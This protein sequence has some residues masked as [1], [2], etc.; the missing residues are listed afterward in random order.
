M[1]VAHVRKTRSPRARYLF[2]RKIPVSILIDTPERSADEIICACLGNEKKKKQKREKRTRDELS[3]RIGADISRNDEGPG[4]NV[5]CA[6]R[7][8]RGVTSRARSSVTRACPMTQREN[9]RR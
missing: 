1:P 2:R 3:R 7:T 8:R 6:L 9:Q 4:R 5:E